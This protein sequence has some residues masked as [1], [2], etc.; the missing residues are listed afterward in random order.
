MIKNSCVVVPCHIP[1]E[2]TTDYIN[3]TVYELAKHNTVIC[4]YQFPPTDGAHPFFR[5]YKKNIY[6]YESPRGLHPRINTWLVRIGIFFLNRKKQFQRRLLWIFDPMHY[7]TATRFGSAFRIVYDCVD[8]WRANPRLQ[9]RHREVVKSEEQKL[10][11]SASVVCVN[12]RVLFRLHHKTRND[13]II[14]PQGFR[15]QSFKGAGKPV[16]SVSTPTVGYVGAIS[17]RLHTPL[18]KSVIFATPHVHFVFAGPILDTDI[19]KEIQHIFS[20]KN[21][22]YLG[23][24]EK[25]DIPRVIA[26][27]DVGMIPYRMNMFNTHCFPMKLFEYFYMGKPVVATDITEL[28]RFSRY[29]RMGTTADA[30]KTIIAEYLLHPVSAASRRDMRKLAIQNSWERKISAISKRINAL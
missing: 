8:F 17:D 27:F 7:Y 10:L 16:K 9:P 3:Q 20:A 5:Q 2:W 24:I 22:T 23:N 18:L 19:G 15:L 21:V 1:W 28:H 4:Y 29:V 30:W 13:I 11:R 14:V 26:G 25:K 6:F 12:S